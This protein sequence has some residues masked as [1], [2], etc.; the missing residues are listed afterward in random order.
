MTNELTEEDK[1]MVADIIGDKMK[2]EFIKMI[3]DF[4]QKAKLNDA[5]FELTQNKLNTLDQKM[6][7]LLNYP[8]ENAKKLDEILRRLPNV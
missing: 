2:D 5:R 6:E 4:K 8:Q 1:K 3:E 7:R